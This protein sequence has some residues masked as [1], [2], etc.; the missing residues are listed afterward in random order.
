[1]NPR[2]LG[3]LCVIGGTAYLMNGLRFF[4]AGAPVED[5]LSGVLSGVWALGALCGVLGMVAVQVT[6]ANRVIR[7]ISYLPVVAFTLV[8]AGIASML[9]NPVDA[10]SPLIAFGLL[11][12][13]IGMLLNGAFTLRAPVWTGWKKAVPFLPAIMPF[14]GMALGNLIGV[15]GGVNVSLVALSWMVLGYAVIT[16]PVTAEARAAAV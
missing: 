7:I 9:A 2:S 5:S 10:F 13:V 4:I 14:V 11:G 1:M 8:L 16:S 12:V 6:G 15:E 3:T